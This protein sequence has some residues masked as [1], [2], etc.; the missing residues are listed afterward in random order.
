MPISW[1]VNI[2]MADIALY[3]DPD[4]VAGKFGLSAF[5]NIYYHLEK[6]VLGGDF[7]LD[8]MLFN[9][10]NDAAEEELLDTTLKFSFAY[11]H[12]A[13][14]RNFY[15]RLGFLGYFSNYSDVSFVTTPFLAPTIGVSYRDI[16]IGN[17]LAELSADYFI[18][19]LFY[20]EMKFAMDFSLNFSLIL[21]DLDNADI[22]IN[23]GVRDSV[24]AMN[25][26]LQNQLKLIISIGVINND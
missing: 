9:F 1:A 22:G 18:G 21:A 4:N 6:M 5:G 19:H 10:G 16:E 14:L 12:E 3:T 15:F 24:F 23:F 13:V 2:G 7:F 20:D 17:I 26:G 8:T 11:S 25:E